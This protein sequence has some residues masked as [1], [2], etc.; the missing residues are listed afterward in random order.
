MSGELR[1]VVEG[2][3]EKIRFHDDEGLLDALR[4]VTMTST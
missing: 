3:S 4:T 2:I 1:R